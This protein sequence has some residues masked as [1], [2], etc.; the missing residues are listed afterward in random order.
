MA[1]ENF[2]PLLTMTAGAD[3]SAKQYFFVSVAA[4][5]QIDPTGDGAQADGVLQDAPS[6]AGDPALVFSGIG[7]TKVSAGGTITAGDDLAS[8]AAGEAITSTSG[9]EILGVAMESGVDGDI[10]TMLLRN[11]SGATA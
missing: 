7:F 8:D 9:D 3:L 6:A 11:G 4:D 10:I 1:T 5:G 2:S